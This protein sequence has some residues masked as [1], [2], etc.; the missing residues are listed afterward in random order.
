M[1]KLVHLENGLALQLAWFSPNCSQKIFNSI[2]TARLFS[3]EVTVHPSKTTV[4]GT[5]FQTGDRGD[6]Q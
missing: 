3:R 6:R 1:S 5:E 4:L 2:A